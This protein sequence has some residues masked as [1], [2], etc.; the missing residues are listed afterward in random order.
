MKESRGKSGMGGGKKSSKKSGKKPHSLHIKRGHSGGFVVTH[1]HMPDETGATQPDEEHVVPDME[2]LHDH[3]DSTMGDQGPAPQ[4]PPP[5]AQAAPA[6]QAP[7]QG[8]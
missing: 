8:M 2:S 3:L 5:E 6:P 7:P 1:R 4:A